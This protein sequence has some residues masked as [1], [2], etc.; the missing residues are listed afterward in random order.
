[1]A[2]VKRKTTGACKHHQCQYDNRS[3]H[4]CVTLFDNACE[5]SGNCAVSFCDHNRPALTAEGVTISL[6]G[7]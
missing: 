7:R 6:K 4:E 2:C 3:G 1:M 5:A